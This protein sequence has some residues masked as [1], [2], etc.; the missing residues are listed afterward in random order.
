LFVSISILKWGESNAAR[1]SSIL[2]DCLDR[3]WYGHGWNRNHG[4][5]YRLDPAAARAT[6][7]TSKSLVGARRQTILVSVLESLRLYLPKFTLEGVLEEINRW[8]RAG[9]SCFARWLNKL[10]L[11]SPVETILDKVVPIPSG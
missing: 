5:E 11:Q 8:E 2:V 3:R 10:K 6:G 7:R 4:G 9:K 1:G